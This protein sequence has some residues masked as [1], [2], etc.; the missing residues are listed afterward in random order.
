[1]TYLE[2]KKVW[3]LAILCM[4]ILILLGRYTCGYAGV[5]EKVEKV[6]QRLNSG[7]VIDPKGLVEEEI[8]PLGQPAIE[9]VIS[10]LKKPRFDVVEGKAVENEDLIW[11]SKVLR[12][13]GD[14]AFSRLTKHVKTGDPY[15][16]ANVL[17]AIFRFDREES[18][19]ILANA[20]TDTGLSEN[21]TPLHR[22]PPRRICDSAYGLLRTKLTSFELPCPD[23]V[24]NFYRLPVKSRDEEIANMRDWW[25]RN[26]GEVLSQF[27]ARLQQR[28]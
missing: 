20:L 5:Q 11:A 8:V 21:K 14:N 24:K 26:K 16:R 1:M 23:K 22:G 17:S 12:F 9:A 7:R 19:I 2:L 10:K 25:G 3:R 27:R 18:F 28:N 4:L 13:I 6:L 15:F